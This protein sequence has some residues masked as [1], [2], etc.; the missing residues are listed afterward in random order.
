M[1]LPGLVR[2]DEPGWAILS[3]QERQERD[4]EIRRQHAERQAVYKQAL[5]SQSHAYRDAALTAM[6]GTNSNCACDGWCA[7]PSV[8]RAT[9]LPS[10]IALLVACAMNYLC[11]MSAIRCT[12]FGEGKAECEC[13]G[14]DGGRRRQG[15][16]HE[17]TDLDH[18]PG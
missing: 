18:A 13:G 3:Y 14:R 17:P 8:C 15:C 9:P 5:T 10:L 4:Q 2:S 16:N 11:V 12:V 1:Y 6:A 7:P